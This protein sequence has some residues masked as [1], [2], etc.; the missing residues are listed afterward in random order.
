VKLLFELSGEHPSLPCQEVESV[1]EII[2]YFP[3]MAIAECPSLLATKRLSLTHVVMEYLGECPAEET[4]ILA[5]LSHL[6]PIPEGSFR[7]RVKKVQG[8]SPHLSPPYLERLVGN[9]ISGAVSLQNPEVEFRLILSG[10]KAFFGRVIHYINRGAYL[11]RDP[12]RR[13]F[14]HPGVMLPR[15]ARA[16]VNLSLIREGELLIDP[17]CGT[18]GMLMEAQMVGAEILGG[19]ADPVMVRGT[20]TNIPHTDVVVED[21]TCLPFCDSCAD[22]VVT[23]L[24]YGQS[25][26]IRGTD[27]PALYEGTLAEIYRIL[28]EGRRVVLI[29][30]RDI[31]H[32]TGAFIPLQYHEQRVHKS[33]TRRIMV[34]KKGQTE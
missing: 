25:V 17:F 5:L 8:S 34:L 2:R 14:F 15:F 4:D 10:E 18:G 30:H 32:L 3:Q 9:H 26:G 11:Y 33:L 19:D 20:R 7:V 24:P 28:K 31:R 13:P 22:A 27:L 1:G 16:M 29:S 21:A 6:Q 12:L 23:D